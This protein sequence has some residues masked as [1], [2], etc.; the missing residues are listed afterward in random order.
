MQQPHVDE[1]VSN[2]FDQISK[3]QEQAI[4]VSNLVALVTAMS[5]IASSVA[6]VAEDKKV[7]LKDLGQLPNLVSGLVKFKDVDLKQALPEVSDLSGE[8]SDELEKAFKEHFKLQDES[9]EQSIEKGF[10]ILLDAYTSIQN[11][12]SIA[13][14][15][16][17]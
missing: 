11:L 2:Q 15:I 3:D 12:K 1:T 6:A 5:V 16:A 17:K 8:E 9:K 13:L 14:Q 4:G 7:N 10:K